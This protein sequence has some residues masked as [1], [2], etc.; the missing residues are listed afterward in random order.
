MN[1]R[2]RCTNI[3]RAVIWDSA[4]AFIPPILLFTLNPGVAWG[5]LLEDV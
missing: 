4:F 3:M 1:A 5:R 2:A